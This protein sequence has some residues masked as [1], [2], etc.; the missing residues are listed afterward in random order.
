MAAITEKVRLGQPVKFTATLERRRVRDARY[1]EEVASEELEG[2]IVGTR[3]LWNG[4]VYTEQLDAEDGGGVYSTFLQSEHKPALLV[5]FALNRKP[6]LVPL[7][8][9]VAA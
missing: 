1:W 8:N 9:A 7:D 6:V 3:T 2:I 4:T 5:A